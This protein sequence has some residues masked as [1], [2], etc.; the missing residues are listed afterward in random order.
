MFMKKVI[1][2]Y[3][4]VEGVPDDFLAAFGVEPNKTDPPPAGGEAGKDPTPEPEPKPEP[5][6]D[7]KQDPPGDPTPAP[8]EKDPPEGGESKKDDPP[9]GP[10]NDHKAQAAFAAMRVENTRFKNTMK[11]IAGILGIQM[12]DDSNALM[13]AIQEKVL[14]AQA[15][16]QNIPIELLQKVQHLEQENEAAKAE[17]LQIAAYRGFQ[18]VK[19]KF[20]LDDKALQDFA[21]QLYKDG[22]NPFVQEIDLVREYRDRNFDKLIAD[23]RAVG[24]R[25]EAERAAKAANHSTVP[26][27]NNGQ[28]GGEAG[29]INTIGSLTDWLNKLQ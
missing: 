14:Q 15:K 24:A 23:A 9:Q 26:G 2:P 20:S 5:E 21:Q 3:N 7:P 8:V 27:T 4:A 28:N 22:I 1:V 19:D 17:R 6:P 12:T 29:K 25:E 11:D 13:A 10:T 18:S 16:Q